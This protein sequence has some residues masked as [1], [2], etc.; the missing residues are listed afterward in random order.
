MAGAGAPGLTTVTARRFWA[1]H[2]EPAQ[3]A[4]VWLRPKAV[5]RTR[6]VATPSSI[7]LWRTASARW[8]DRAMLSSLVPESSA[9]PSTMIMRP[10]LRLSHCACASMAVRARTLSSALRSAKKTRSP[11]LMR[12]SRPMPAATTSGTPS[13]MRSSADPKVGH[14]KAIGPAKTMARPSDRPHGMW[15]A[16]PRLMHQ[17]HTAPALG[18]KFDDRWRRQGR[19]GGAGPHLAAKGAPPGGL[20]T[21]LGA[22]VQDGLGPPVLRPTGDVVAHGHRALL[23][24]GDGADAAGVDA[25]PGQEVAHRLGPSGAQ[26]DVVFTRAALVGVALNRDRILGILLQP[27]RLI[28]QGL[29]RLG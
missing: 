18:P 12:K 19:G 27:L 15:R 1:A 23:A 9:W 21:R 2:R 13:C 25:V 14:P 7:N 28:R 17:G 4:T 11:T 5:T 16:P 3:S 22:S 10:G 29:L 26:G 6:S 24:V 20:G 8:R